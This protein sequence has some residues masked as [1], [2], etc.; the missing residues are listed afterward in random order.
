MKMDVFA[1]LGVCGG[2]VACIIA[3]SAMYSDVFGSVD[4]TEENTVNTSNT[5]IWVFSCKVKFYFDV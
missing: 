3:V 2:S 5:P 4:S 1:V